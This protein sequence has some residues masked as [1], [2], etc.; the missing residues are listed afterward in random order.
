MEVCVNYEREI[1]HPGVEKDAA[2]LE[3]VRQQLQQQ[4]T[5]GEA[6]FKG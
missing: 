6:P 3:Q 1:G 4:A 2:Q 5:R